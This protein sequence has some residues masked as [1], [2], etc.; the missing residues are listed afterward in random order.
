[1]GRYLTITNSNTAKLGIR[2][3]TLPKKLKTGP[4]TLTIITLILVCL[5]SLF[6]LAQ[7]FDSSTKGYQM[8]D[9]KKKAEELR[10]ENRKLQVKAAELK[11]YKHIEEEAK[12]LNMLPSTSI[13]YINSTSG[14][15][16]IAR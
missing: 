7:L 3:Q 15:V 5:L 13:V 1:M 2:K 9:L 12:K 16:V 14:T 11:S 6:Y 4:I 10:E 8:S